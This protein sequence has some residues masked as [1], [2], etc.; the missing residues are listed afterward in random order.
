MAH[1]EE[2]KI[3]DAR[4]RQKIAEGIAAGIKEYQVLGQQALQDHSPR[5]PE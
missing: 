1:A 5:S 2:K 3:L 4:F